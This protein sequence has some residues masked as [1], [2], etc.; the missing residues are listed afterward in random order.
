MRKKFN[1]G[2]AFREGGTVDADTKKELAFM[3]AK[4]APK[5]MVAAEKKEHGLEGGG[6]PGKSR[7]V[8]NGAFNIKAPPKT[9]FADGGGVNPQ[10][11]MAVRQALAKRALMQQAA[12]AQGAQQGAMPQ[13]PMPPQGGMPQRPMPQG[14][15]PQRRM[16]PQGGVPPQAMPPQGVAPVMAKGGCVKMAKGGSV[17]GDGIAQRGRTK[18]KMV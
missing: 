13:R 16:P 11:A 1:L 7:Y 17:H 15:M 14:G 9:K 3:K 18:G 5:S 12:A 8:G 10:E 4:G 6:S 2:P